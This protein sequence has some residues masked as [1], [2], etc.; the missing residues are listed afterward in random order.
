MYMY[1][2]LRP[3]EGCLMP[4]FTFRATDEAAAR[5]DA[6]VPYIASRPDALAL[7]GGDV[8]RSHM[9]RMV[10]MRGLDV[11]EAEAAGDVEKPPVPDAGEG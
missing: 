10:L 4:I 5:L 11:L 9:L 7:T 3:K 8:R 6:L 1:E 2:E